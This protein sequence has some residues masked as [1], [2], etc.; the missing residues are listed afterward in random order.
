MRFLVLAV[1][2]AALS[3]PASAAETQRD[4]CAP[5]GC[6]DGDWTPIKVQRHHAK[7]YPVQAGRRAARNRA[8]R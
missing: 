6:F 8:S 4:P 3:L 1:I 5:R 7:K 2:A